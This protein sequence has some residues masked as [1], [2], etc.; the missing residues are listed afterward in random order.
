MCISVNKNHSRQRQRFT[1]AHELGH[2]L[3]HKGTAIHVDRN[4]RVNFRNGASSQATDLEGLPI[5]MS[6]KIIS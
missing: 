5:F 3:L 4:F 6:L 2:F 1:I